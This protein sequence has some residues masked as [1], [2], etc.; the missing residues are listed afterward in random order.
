[1]IGPQT[2]TRTATQTSISLAFT[3]LQMEEVAE[4][5]GHDPALL[6][7]VR[8]CVPRRVLQSVSIFGIRPGS[9]REAHAYLQV[10]VDYDGPGVEVNVRG[11]SGRGNSRYGFGEKDTRHGCPKWAT[12]ITMHMQLIEDRGLQPQWAVRWVPTANRN[13]LNAEFGLVSGIVDDRTRGAATHHLPNSIAP[14]MALFARY[15]TDYYPEE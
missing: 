8:S 6:E 12:A 10:E 14:W 15:S 7:I 2:Q 5:S 4:L 11:G 3:A 1:M 13:A 9:D